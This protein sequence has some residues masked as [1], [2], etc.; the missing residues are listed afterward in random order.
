MEN[1]ITI[2]KE[3]LGNARDLVKQL[4]AGNRLLAY[5]KTGKLDGLH[6]F[7]FTKGMAGPMHATTSEIIIT[8]LHD[9]QIV[10]DIRDD[11]MHLESI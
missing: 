10:T 7:T 9:V 1:E 3:P 4:K 5:Q 11:A 6:K 8:Y 2:D